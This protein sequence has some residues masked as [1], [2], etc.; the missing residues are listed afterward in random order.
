METRRTLVGAYEHLDPWP[1]P[2]AVLGRLKR[3][4]LKLAPLANFTP[5]M[6]EN[7]LRHGGVRDY[8]DEVLSTDRVKSYKPDP[9][10]D[11]M[12]PEARNR[13]SQLGFSRLRSRHVE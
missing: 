6:I 2:R 5:T 8:F 11:P 9:P 10:M 1:D 12:P 3:A 13:I 7:L 4:G